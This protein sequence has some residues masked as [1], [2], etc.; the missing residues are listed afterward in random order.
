VRAL[1]FA[2]SFLPFAASLLSVGSAASSSASLSPAA[3]LFVV[4][5]ALRFC[6]AAATCER[7]VDRIASFTKPIVSSSPSVRSSSK[8]VAICSRA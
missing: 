1:T 5:L 4:F 7:A 8:L 6:G 3:L 2:V